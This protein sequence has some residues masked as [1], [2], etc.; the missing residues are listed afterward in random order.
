MPLNVLWTHTGWHFQMRPC[1]ASEGEEPV[2]APCPAWVRDRCAGEKAGA[3]HPECEWN[4][5]VA[6]AW[7]QSSQPVKKRMKHVEYGTLEKLYTTGLSGIT[8]SHYFIC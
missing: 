2:S 6:A 7:G 4:G 3:L 5:N 8:I 1:A